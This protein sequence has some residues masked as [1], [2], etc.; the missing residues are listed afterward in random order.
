M[1]LLMPV[2]MLVNVEL[3]IHENKYLNLIIGKPKYHPYDLIMVVN[4]HVNLLINI[5]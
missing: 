2:N 4:I 1:L 3:N 5:Q